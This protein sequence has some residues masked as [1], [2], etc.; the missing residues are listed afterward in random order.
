MFYKFTYCKT[1]AIK[2]Q[3]LLQ[4]LLPPLYCSGQILL[5]SRK[6]SAAL[7]DL[8]SKEE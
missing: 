8:K 6:D 7:T 3:Q 1:D 5:P 2:E 4:L